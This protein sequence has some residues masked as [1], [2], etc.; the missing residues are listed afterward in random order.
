MISE[1]PL[2]FEAL[3][4]TPV[5]AGLEEAALHLLAKEGIVHDFLADEI[6]VREG[7]PGHS[8]YILVEGEVDVI[9]NLESPNAVSLATL[10]SPTFFGEM[11]VIDPVP[12]AATVF[13]VTEARALEIKNSTLHHLYKQMPEQYAI[14]ILNIARDLVRRLRKLDETFA[15]RAC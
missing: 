4:K 10:K 7:D 15:A 1:T 11:C 6:I 3:A 2:L 13:S 8:F 9:K 12:R 14:V 5:L